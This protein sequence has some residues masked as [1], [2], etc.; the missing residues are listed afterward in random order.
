MHHCIIGNIAPDAKKEE[1]TDGIVSYQSSH[2]ENA[3]S[4]VIVP[5]GH[6]CTSYPL[7]I[8]EVKRILELH[9]HEEE[10]KSKD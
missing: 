9:Y 1:W 4:E 10:K 2:L 7:T 3:E 6:T 5:H 8:K